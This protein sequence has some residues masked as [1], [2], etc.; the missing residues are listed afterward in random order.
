MDLILLKTIMNL[1]GVIAILFLILI[2]MCFLYAI[3]SFIKSV[4]DRIRGKNGRV[5]R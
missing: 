5:K 1:A 4:I 3:G 2:V